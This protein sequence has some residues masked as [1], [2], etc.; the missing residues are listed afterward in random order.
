MFFTSAAV[1]YR[2][3]KYCVLRPATV[4]HGVASLPD[5]GG[6]AEVFRDAVMA[7][8]DGHDDHGTLHGLECAMS[9]LEPYRMGLDVGLA[10]GDI[11]RDEPL[12]DDIDEVAARGI[13]D[14]VGTAALVWRYWQEY[15]DADGVE[16]LEAL[17][18]L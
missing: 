11:L 6:W 13:D 17:G 12:P 9:E 2:Y 7:F 1:A 3:C 10:A 14:R 16:V 18:V 15:D 5:S 8:R 4:R